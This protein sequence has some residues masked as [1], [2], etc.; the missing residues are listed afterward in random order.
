MNTLIIYSSQ[1]L[2]Y[3]LPQF[4]RNVTST[5]PATTDLNDPTTDLSDPT[6]DPDDPTTDLNDPSSPD[7]TPWLVIA[8]IAFLLIVGILIVVTVILVWWRKRKNR[9]RFENRKSEILKPIP[10][11]YKQRQAHQSEMRAQGSNPAYRSSIDDND[12]MEGEEEYVEVTEPSPP[13]EQL[14]YEEINEEKQRSE[15]GYLERDGEEYVMTVD[16]FSGRAGFAGQGPK[17]RADTAVAPQKRPKPKYPNSSHD[18]TNAELKKID[19]TKSGVMAGVFVGDATD[20]ARGSGKSSPHYVNDLDRISRHLKA[21]NLG[22]SAEQKPQKEEQQGASG[23]GSNPNYVNNLAHGTE[24]DEDEEG[25][26][27]F[28][29]LKDGRGQVGGGRGQVGD[30]YENNTLQ[31]ERDE[32]DKKPDGTMIY[33]NSPVKTG[34][35]IPDE[36]THRKTDSVNYVNDLGALLRQA[37]LQEKTTEPSGSGPGKHHPYVNDLASMVQDALKSNELSDNEDSHNYVNDLPGLL[38]SA[39]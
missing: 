8:V 30:I 23:R 27:V 36:D 6:T 4:Y 33:E 25:Y 22:G 2:T 13:G 37:E 29:P 9:I 5:E 21:A 26:T 7:L 11:Q 28:D 10:V 34:Q 16:Q 24:S 31:V 18:R 32:L 20:S 3:P 39:R 19:N 1:K 17:P 35:P 12:V 15:S 14:L 38:P